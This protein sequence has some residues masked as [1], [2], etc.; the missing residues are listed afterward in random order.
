MKRLVVVGGGISGLAT[1]FHAGRTARKAGI[2]LSV[3]VLDASSRPGGKMWSERSDGFVIEHGPNGFL[4]NKPH[5]LDLV[6]ALGG[7]DELLPASE[8]AG[9]RFVCRRGR[10]EP[11]PISPPDFFKSRLLSAGGKLR[12]LM[13]PFSRRAP[14]GVDE[15]VS[16]FAARR[17][18][19]QA[20][21]YLI[22]PMVSGVFAGDPDRLSLAAAFPRIHELEREYGGLFKALFRLRRESRRKGVRGPSGAGPGGTLTSFR[23]GVSTLVEMLCRELGTGLVMDARV[24]GVEPA[25]SG[26][27]AETRRSDGGIVRYGADAVVFCCPSYEAGR[28]IEGLEQT[29]AGLLNSIEYSPVTVVA[30][31]FDRED[32][33]TAVDGFGFLVP[34]LEGRPVLGTLWDS[35]V[36]GDRSPEGQVLL[37]TMVGGARSPDLAFLDDDKITAS[38][39]DQIREL[40]G[41]KAN[42]TLVRVIRHERGIPQ[43]NVGHIGRIREID[44]ALAGTE[45][46][47][48]CNNAYRGVS[49]N[50]CAREAA[51]TA[52]RVMEF[53]Q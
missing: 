23:G 25:G 13:E 2:P 26:F 40:N 33:G 9:K 53:L 48:L 28:L 34:R 38:A 30:T 24:T 46:I 1:A 32:V 42:P 39:L 36:F 37:R 43:Y 44:A 27:E 49:L 6:S 31:A 18:G 17:L 5:T 15:S 21:D 16:E 12:V 35:S 3:T 8:L 11:L 7:E 50:D 14:E 19:P 52:G 10:L 20:G 51:G 47:F 45:G 41:I 4:D 22:D 29:L